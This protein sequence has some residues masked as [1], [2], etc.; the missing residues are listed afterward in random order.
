[1]EQIKDPDAGKNVESRSNLK[2]DC[3]WYGQGRGKGC[4]EV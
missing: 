4:E 1:M 2:N 3:G